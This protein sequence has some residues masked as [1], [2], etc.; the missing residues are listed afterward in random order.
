[1]AC[2]AVLKIGN[3]FVQVFLADLGFIVFMTTVTRINGNIRRM[4]GDTARAVPMA[5]W[6]RMRTIEL[7]GN[8]GVGRMAGCTVR[9]KV[10]GVKHRFGMAGRTVPRGR[11]KIS[12]AARVHMALRTGN[13]RM[14]ARQRKGKKAVIE[15][16]IEAV[17]TIVTIEAS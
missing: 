3:P 7:S 4:A 9:S 17:H 11:C 14:P 2:R 16:L 15:I 13:L 8:P 10:P 6:K 1:M 12:Q 5:E